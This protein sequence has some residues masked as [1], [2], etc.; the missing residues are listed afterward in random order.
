MARARD[1]PPWTVRNWLVHGEPVFIKSTFG[2]AFW[3]GN[4][5]GSWGTDKVPKAVAEAARLDNDGTLRGVERALWEARY[6]TVYIDD[7]SLKPTGYRDFA[8]LS[9]PARSRLLLHR[10]WQFIHA[11]PAVYLRLCLKRLQ[12]FLLFDETNPKAS[13]RLYRITTVVWLV[14]AVVGA[15]V[16]WPHRRRLWPTYAVF[17]AVMLFHTLVI[18]SARF[19]IPVEP[20]SL[21]L[22]G[23]GRRA[24]GGTCR[25]TG[26]WR[27]VAVAT[28]GAAVSPTRLHAARLRRPKAGRP[29]PCP[30]R[31][32]SRDRRLRACGVEIPPPA[33]LLF[34]DT[35]PGA[36]PAEEFFSGRNILRLLALWQTRLA[37]CRRPVS[38]LLAGKNRTTCGRRDWQWHYARSGTG[39]IGRGRCFPWWDFGSQSGSALH[40]GPESL[41]DRISLP[42]GRLGPLLETLGRRGPC[43]R[44]LREPCRSGRRFAACWKR[45]LPASCSR[46]YGPRPSA[47]TTAG[48]TS[49]TENRWCGAFSSAI[50]KR[51]CRVLSLLA[52]GPG[53][54]VEHA[55]KLDHLRRRC[56]RWCDMLV[57]Y[58]LSSGDVSEFAVDPARA[59]DFAADLHD[60]SQ[61]AGG[62]HAWSLVQVSLRAA[63]RHDLAPV[64][65][66]AE[67]N[68]Q[69]AAAV[70]A[71]IPQAAFDSTG[72]LHTLWAARL[73]EAAN[74]AQGLIEELLGP[75]G[76]FPPAADGAATSG[77]W[78]NRARRFGK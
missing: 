50:R 4:S 41:L 60:Q 47:L 25:R 53:I 24:V 14:L 68:A 17:L 67:F 3:Q 27:M 9:E 13:H 28:R 10:A 76:S 36:E 64:S 35:G 6:V 16:S 45:S 11:N 44:P 78:P 33:G 26:D 15:L 61:S 74:D 42:L 73:L 23:G 46:G 19:R 18:V 12:Y 38:A 48:T 32:S 22:G 31:I 2:Y 75:A 57:G 51:V 40:R 39:G 77:A 66:H 72:I 63:F 21:H 70:L 52:Q 59:R 5:P 7:L 65:P 34:G 1:H 55:M 43:P 20:L 54:D 71:C 30:G 8:G 62:R 69:I 37:A 56:D 58:L 49:T 29:T